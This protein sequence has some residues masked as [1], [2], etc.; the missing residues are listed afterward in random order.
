M[1][2]TNIAVWSTGQS[3]VGMKY[4][5]IDYVCSVFERARGHYV[6]WRDTWILD[7]ILDLKH[8]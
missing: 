7:I 4:G 2:F 3:G 8:Y 5:V 1:G 6:A